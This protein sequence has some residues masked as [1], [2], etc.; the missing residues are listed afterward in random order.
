MYITRN[1]VQRSM[2][3]IVRSFV[4]KCHGGDVVSCRN[5]TIRFDRPVVYGY[6]LY[7]CAHMYAV[8]GSW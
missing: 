2:S 6:L 1:D 4:E 8:L 5:I 7:T 3:N